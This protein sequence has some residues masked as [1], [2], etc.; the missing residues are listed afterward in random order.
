MQK[1]YDV[2]VIGSGGGIKIA[3]PAAARGKRVAFI[4]E[5]DPGGTCLNRGCIPSKMIIYPTELADT[6]RRAHRLNV[7]CPVP[8]VIDFPALMGR[9]AHTIGKV[10][11]GLRRD[12]LNTPNLDYIAGHAEFIANK[13]LRVGDR[14][15]TGDRI[16]I[17][18][19]SRPRIPP[20]PG[21][22]QT[23]FMTS[24]EALTRTTLPQRMLVIGAGYI[25]VEL[26]S[27]YRAAG[28]TVSYLVRSSLLRREDRDISAEFH[29]VFS[30]H[31][32]LHERTI[33]YQVDYADGDFLVHCTLHN[34]EEVTLKSD[35]LLVAA[36]VTPNS[37][38]LGLANTDILTTEDGF[39]R[40]D[41]YLRTTVPGV[42]A[43]GDVAGNY[44]FRH[45]VNYEGEYLMRTAFEAADPAPIDY[46]PVP[47]AV[48]AT[49]EVAGVGLTEEEAR[50]QDIDLI[51]G[52]ATYADSTPG[53]ARESDHG[54]VKILVE[55]SSRRLLGAHIVGEEAANMIH[56]FVAMMKK[57]ATLE[58]LLDMIFVHPALP[59]VARDAARDAARRDAGV[60]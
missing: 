56:L 3:K 7:L 9:T 36:G 53:M 32:E 44:L 48:F 20:I 35:A 10:A 49:P 33:A 4:E 39:I 8:P 31:Q 22:A 27:A 16:F 47:H 46:G 51:I 37:D 14:V 15:I 13:T 26:G 43:L 25:A 59:E 57:Q 23:P 41:N 50:E 2:I 12:F 42:Y 34:G 18:T 60:V 28:A 54:L 29:R 5:R 21:L 24:E 19:G 45:T 38:K 17:A 6:I 11:D 58:D 1:A 30:Q 40:V 52:R 55:R